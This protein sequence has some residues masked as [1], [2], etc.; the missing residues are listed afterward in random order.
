MFYDRKLL[1]VAIIYSFL[2]EAAQRYDIRGKAYIETPRKYY[3][4]MMPSSIAGL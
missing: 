3:F 2:L 4:S 1:K